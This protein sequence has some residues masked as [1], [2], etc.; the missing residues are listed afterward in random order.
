M[1]SPWFL[2]YITLPLS[3]CRLH[4]IAFSAASDLSLSLPR[5]FLFRILMMAFGS[6][7]DGQRWEA[8][9]LGPEFGLEWESLSIVGVEQSA[10]QARDGVSFLYITVWYLQRADTFVPVTATRET[11]RDCYRKELVQQ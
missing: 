6:G 5:P 1:T 11:Q 7:F 2:L 4:H 10:E 9:R 3:A 8:K